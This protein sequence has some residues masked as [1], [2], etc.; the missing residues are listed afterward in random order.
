[1]LLNLFV[2]KSSEKIQRTE[3]EEVIFGNK[4]R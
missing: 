2:S 1:M 3:L 4:A